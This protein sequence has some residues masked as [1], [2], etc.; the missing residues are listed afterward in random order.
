MGVCGVGVCGV[1]VSGQQ[2]K[3]KRWRDV[4]VVR[5][6]AWRHHCGG[7]GGGRGGCCDFKGGFSRINLGLTPAAR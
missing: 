7:G 1:G 5:L 4:S 3:V 2:L 6:Q